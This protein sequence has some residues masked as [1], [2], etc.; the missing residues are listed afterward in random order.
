[1]S[2]S[3]STPLEAAAAY[4]LWAGTYDAENPLTT[5]DGR[6]AALLTPPLPGKALLD[7]AC[8][9][10]RRL[11]FADAPPGRA[12]GIDL[13]FEMLRKGRADR[14]RPRATAVGDLR[15]LPVRPAAFDVV[16]C[17]L[18]A[19]HLDNLGPLYREIARTLAPGGVTIV[20]DFHPDA[21]RAG[22]RR[23]F[24]DA[25][26]R[27]HLVEHVLHEPDAHESAAERA[28]LRLEMR[29]DLPIDESLRVFWERSDAMGRFACDKGLLL[30]L[31]LRFRR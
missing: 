24:R 30:L 1:M 23:V 13:V 20:T 19:G 25:E 29:L 22:H 7:A 27:P 6:A 18:A 11:V 10:A 4:R 21:I 15:A 28:G 17:R 16:W 5:L 9:T 26:G 12:I 8:G 31:A 2:A 3:P 14:E